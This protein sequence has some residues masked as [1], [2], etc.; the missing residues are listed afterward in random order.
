VERLAFLYPGQGSQKVG[1]GADLSQARPDLLERYLD[2]ADQISG[3]PVRRYCFEGPIESLTQTQVAQ[4]ALF[5]LSLAVTEAA[6]EVG[7]RA[8]FVAGHSLGEYTAAVAAGVLDAEDGMA[9]VSERG[10]RMEEI[11]SQR[12]GAMAA[13]IGLPLESVEELCEQASDHGVV[14][15]ANLNA[16]TQIVVSGEER[17][18]ERLVELADRAGAR[19]AL[20]LQVGAAFHSELMK[21]VQEGLEQTM[22]TLEWRDPDAPLAANFS[23]QL[24][25]EGEEVHQA[26]IAQIASPVRWVECVQS[27]LAAGCTSFLELGPGRVLTGL[28]RQ[29][30]PSADVA[31]ADSPEKL[32]AFLE[33][34]PSL[35]H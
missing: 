17:A 19:K 11:Q 13:V 2:R 7:L 15:L 20:R 26:L 4:P 29:I 25:T 22:K 5:A 35:V 32:A 6:R 27:L 14:A 34:R 23:G 8:D 28:V 30:E 16:P 31:A 9:L 1:M 21:P 12:P 33:A 24:L 3:L 10:R 18:V